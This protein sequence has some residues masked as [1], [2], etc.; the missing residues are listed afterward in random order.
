M[1]KIF[2]LIAASLISVAPMMAQTKVNVNK[3]AILGKIAKSDAD[4]A[5]PK[6]AAKSTTWINRGKALMDAETAISGNL[7]ENMDMM[8]LNLLFGKAPQE[9]QVEK[10]G[11]AF[12]QLVYPDFVAYTDGATVQGWEI[13]NIIYEGALDK[14]IEAYKKAYELS[15]SSAAKVQEALKEVWNAVLK[16]ASN[17]YN[18]GEFKR[19]G[20]YFAK[21]Y[22]LSVLPYSGMEADYTS[23]YSAGL[24][25]IYC[26]EFQPSYDNLVIARDGGVEQDGDVYY[27]M[28]H[29]YKGI[30]NGDKAKLAE[31]EANLTAGLEKYPNNSKIIECMTDLYV[32][33]ERDPSQIVTIVKAAIDKDPNNASLWNGL[34]RVYDQLGDTDSAINA[35]HKVAE[36]QPTD[37][38]GFW[39]LG[40]LYIRKGDAAID[41][42]NKKTFT[43]QAEYDADLN[44]ANEIYYNALAPLEKAHELNPSELPILEYLKNLC[45][46]LRDY[47]PEIMDKY[48][49]YNEEFKAAKQ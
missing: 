31:A 12:T 44:A 13:T 48:N 42:L 6:K 45:F 28:Y 29:A 3:D 27:I 25:Y 18:L 35:F 47:K 20:D 21:A 30:C 33:L 10:G 17:A 4:I 11:T 32:E 2:L 8:T 1:K 19:A 39:S 14:A 38:V 41:A 40:I 24:S 43:G 49:K 36:L 37:Y 15:S 16:E 46:R 9:A 22:E 5:N 23:A 7:F 26:N 34:G